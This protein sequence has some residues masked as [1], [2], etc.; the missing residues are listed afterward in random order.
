VTL[1]PVPEISNGEPT[2]IG[3]FCASRAR[4]ATPLP[5]MVNSVPLI[6]DWSIAVPLGLW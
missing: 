6:V 5:V 3:R 4:S 1:S 2:R